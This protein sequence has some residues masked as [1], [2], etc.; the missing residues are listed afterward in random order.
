MPEEK[1]RTRACHIYLDGVE[2]D[3]VPALAEICKLDN[4]Y[5]ALFAKVM[6]ERKTVDTYL[7]VESNSPSINDAHLLEIW[8]GSAPPRMRAHEIGGIVKHL[9]LGLKEKP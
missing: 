4:W 8:I 5:D 3:K 9:T 2:I 1:K 7:I 6:S